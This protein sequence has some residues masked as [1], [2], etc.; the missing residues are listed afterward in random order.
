MDAS[1][2]V[3]AWLCRLPLKQPIPVGAARWMDRPTVL[4]SLTD[5][6]GHTGWGEAAPLDGYGPDT[7]SDVVTAI[8]DGNWDAA[9]PSLQCALGTARQATASPSGMLLTPAVLDPTSEAPLIK[10]KISGEPQDEASRLLAL[11]QDHPTRRLRLDANRSLTR[12]GARRL[13]DMIGPLVDRIDFFEEPFPG[14]FETDHRTDFPVSL[15]IDESLDGE[16]WRH[17]D[18]CV[19]KPS[20]MGD[21]RTTFRLAR[22]MQTDGRRVV[23][24]SAFESRVGML[25]L[26]HLADQLGDAAPGLSTYTWLAD[27]VGGLDPL[28]SGPLLDPASL[29]ALPAPLADPSSARFPVEVIQ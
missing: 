4:I 23:V 26:V 7:L 24:S 13:L 20:L 18:V 22:A 19:L 28:L 14:C 29:P 16:N 12:D 11:L 6:D 5:R 25:M 1:V 17:A 21:P 10:V 9:L 2:T 8:R 27:D 15:A 3:R